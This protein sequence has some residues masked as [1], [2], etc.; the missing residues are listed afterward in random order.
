MFSINRVDLIVDL[1]KYY[2]ALK[3]ILNDFPKA[4][5]S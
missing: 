1:L 2:W 5:S 4:V 3:G